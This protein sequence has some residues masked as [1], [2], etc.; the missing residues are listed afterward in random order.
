[1]VR[2]EQLGMANRLHRICIVVLALAAVVGAGGSARLVEAQAGQSRAGLVVQFPN[3]E[4]RTYCIAFEGDSISGLDLLLKS[5]L[6]VKVEVLG[7]L[8]AWI[9]KINDTGCTYPEQP[10][11][12][13]SYG[14]GGVYWSYHH[15]KEG[16]WRASVLGAGSYKVHDGDVEGWVWSDGSPPNV[17]TFDQL[18]PAEQPQ[19]TDTAPPPPPAPTDTP[20][21]PTQVPTRRPVSTSTSRPAAP[22]MT[23]RVV[24]TAVVAQPTAT[25]AP[26]A[27]TDTLVPVPSDTPTA[28]ATAEATAPPSATVTLTA[29]PMVTPSATATSSATATAAAGTVAGSQEDA[30]RMVG[31][32]IGAGVLGALA[33]WGVTVALKRGR[34]GGDS[35]HVG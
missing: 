3:G 9:C 27:P 16:K 1:M 19:P 15:L 18:C 10:C 5:G 4:A 32:V 35:S 17:Y 29:T 20:V 2:E 12:C 25:S 14:P 23:V 7:G 28:T 31:I 33:L 11:V 26:P 13:Q 21:P 22:I 6:D 8:G 34:P 24:E 30:G